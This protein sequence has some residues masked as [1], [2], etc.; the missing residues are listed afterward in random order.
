MFFQCIENRDTDQLCDDR[1]A[2]LR[3]LFSHMRKQVFSGRLSNCIALIADGK[4]GILDTLWTRH[5]REYLTN[6][7]ISTAYGRL[8]ETRG[9]ADERLC[10]RG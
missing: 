9:L 5:Y 6:V 3:F 7:E 4:R 8:A 10:H 1:A 2:D